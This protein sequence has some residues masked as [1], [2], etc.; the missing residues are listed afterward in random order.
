MSEETRRCDKCS[1]WEEWSFDEH[2]Q[3][4]CRRYAPRAMIKD[5]TIDFDDYLLWP[6]TR[7]GSW[8]GE[9]QPK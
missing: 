4:F 7:G 8:C 3:G 9:F 1:F 5:I 2:P 6:T